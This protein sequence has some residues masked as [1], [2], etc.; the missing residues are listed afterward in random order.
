MSKTTAGDA[1]SKEA[2]L[3]LGYKIP[4]C[5]IPK[6]ED[7]ARNQYY[8]EKYWQLDNC[9]NVLKEIAAK[10]PC[11]GLAWIIENKKWPFATTSYE[12]RW[13]PDGVATGSFS[14]VKVMLYCRNQS[15]FR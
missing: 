8:R 13:Y 7:L 10:E 4:E 11:D 12:S 2:H 5:F 15:I 9:I 3:P 1:A 14:V 6:I